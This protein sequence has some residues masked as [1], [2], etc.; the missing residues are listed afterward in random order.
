MTEVPKTY[1][2]SVCVANESKS[3][4]KS[5]I[6][7]RNPDN[8]EQGHAKSIRLVKVRAEASSSAKTRQI[9]HDD[10]FFFS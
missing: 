4:I 2:G 10:L 9:F 8:V 7:G 1:I 6:S 5:F 3:G